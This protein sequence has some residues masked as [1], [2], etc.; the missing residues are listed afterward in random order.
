[1]IFVSVTRLGLPPFPI[2]TSRLVVRSWSTLKLLCLSQAE[3]RQAIGLIDTPEI[4]RQVPVYQTA[5]ACHLN[6][7]AM[8][9]PGLPVSSTGVVCRWGRSD[10]P[11]R[12][13]CQEPSLALIESARAMT[14]LVE[15]FS[16]EG[17]EHGLGDRCPVR[18]ELNLPF[19]RM[20][21]ALETTLC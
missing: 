17:R 15:P 12:L 7:N 11:S 9:S 4:D 10:R 2:H 1:M 13:N 14:T 18:Q 6:G 16:S 8:F 21:L 5:R 19:V 3:N 20:V